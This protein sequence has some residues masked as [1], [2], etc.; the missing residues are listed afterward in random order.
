MAPYVAVGYSQGIL[1]LGFGSLNVKVTE[2]NLQLIVLEL[3]AFFKNAHEEEEAYK[4][5][6]EKELI[7]EGLSILK[8]KSYLV[9][10]SVWKEVPV[11]FQ[12]MSLALLSE[13]IDPVQAFKNISTK[14]IMIMGCGAIG[15]SMAMLL[16]TIGIK[17]LIL[18]DEDLYDESNTGRSTHI[19]PSMIGKN[20]A[21]ALRDIVIEKNPLINVE[22]HSKKLEQDVEYILPS[23]GFVILSADSSYLLKTVNAICVRQK[24]PF[25]Q[26][27]YAHDQAVWGP[28]VVPGETGCI[29]CRSHTL[30]PSSLNEREKELLAFINTG[31]IAPA[32]SYLAQFSVSLAIEDLVRFFTNRRARALNHQI[33]VSMHDL[34]VQNLA[35]HSSE[36]CFCQTRY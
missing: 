34:Q 35:Y 31:Y 29:A 1:N 28:L 15:T 17:R 14:E 19:T 16:A 7:H 22:A 12:R 21:Q 3:C 23:C 5:P 18:I 32:P 33:A 24:I 11:F 30:Q 27:G 6:F 26:V 2:K 20:K 8:S 4:L 36:H 13:G 9:R 25:M 10:D